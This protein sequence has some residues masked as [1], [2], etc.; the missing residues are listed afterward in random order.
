MSINAKARQA[1]VDISLKHILFKK[2]RAETFTEKNRQSDKRTARKII[3]LYNSLHPDCQILSE[4]S[5]EYLTIL[6]LIKK[7]DYT[8][9]KNWLIE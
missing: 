5:S 8:A 4:K 3:A 6:E 7:A 9:I 2:K 1:M